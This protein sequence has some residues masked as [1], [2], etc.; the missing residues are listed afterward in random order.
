MKKSAIIFDCFGV[1]CSKPIE[2]WM[3]DTLGDTPEVMSYFHD[4]AHRFD[5]S[6]ISEM[7]LMAE[8][9]VRANKSATEVREE[10]D[11][12][13]SFNHD[14]ASYI[15]ELKEKG[16]VTALLSN[17]NHETFERRILAH[18]P[19]F[20]PLFDHLVISSEVGLRKPNPEIYQHVLSKLAVSP[21]EAVF[22]DDNEE[23]TLAA[24]K[25][26]IESI[27]YTNTDAVKSGFKRLGINV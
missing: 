23:N 4:V 17:G 21:E 20:R 18:N 2:T 26:G 7:D 19:W 3:R 13:L 14:L 15:K 22:V 1:L 27:L 12:Y 8:M 25:L 24:Q 10:I 11:A 6:L 5:L 16:Y 9:G